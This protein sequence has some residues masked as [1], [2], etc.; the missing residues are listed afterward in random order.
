MI[1]SG[2]AVV[3][4]IADARGGTIEFRDEKTDAVKTAQP[5]AHSGAFRL[6]LPRGR[7]AIR[8]GA[9]HSSLTVLSAG[10]YNV[11]LRH[12]R[13]FDFTVISETAAD[14]AVTVRLSAHGA[15]QH[16]FSIRA[17]NLDLSDADAQTLDLN[18]EKTNEGSGK[19]ADAVWHAHVVSAATPWVAVV[20][21]DDVME[22]RQEVT[23]TA[24][25]PQENQA[26]AK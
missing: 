17:D 19:K 13:A 15:G 26:S 2:P 8:Q 12:D 3:R 4:G 21:P 18:S 7:Y 1:S 23:G 11:E 16:R 10:N 20:I 22:K 5:D 14:G 6:L 9:T 24:A 25:K